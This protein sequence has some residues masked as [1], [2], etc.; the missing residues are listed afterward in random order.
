MTASPG[1][2]GST[3]RVDAAA[4]PTDYLELARELSLIHGRVMVSRESSGIHFYM[5]S[6][7]CLEKDGRI[8]LYKRHLA[9]NADK[10][11]QKGKQRCAMCMKTSHPYTIEELLEMP[12]LAERGIKD[13][14]KGTALVTVAETNPDDL[15]ADS[16]GRLVPKVAGDLVPAYQLPADHPAR[17]YLAYREFDALRL[18]QQFRLSWCE[19]ERVDRF[20]RPLPLGFAATPQGRLVFHV[21]M[22]GKS[23][24]WQARV[25]ELP[26]EDDCTLFWWH[27]Y[28]NE[29]FPV[30]QRNS[31]EEKWE[32][33]PETVSLCKEMPKYLFGKGQARNQVLMGLDAAIAWNRGRQVPVC[34]LAEGAF[35]A[36]RA[37]PPGIATLGKFISPF[38]TEILVRHFKRIV[39]VADNDEAGTYAK[40]KLAD[41]LKEHSQVE[42]HFVAPPAKDLGDTPPAVAA[43]LLKGYL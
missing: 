21:D 23:H 27:P 34:I 40:E 9:V 22:M 1:L 19:L 7:E 30:K 3:S 6:P 38:Q 36:G 35:D 12:P 20:H 16:Q 26:S 14:P 31:P 5:A 11:I 13:A 10:Y 39:Y 33:L 37:G 18:Y 25:L 8:E 43:A 24:G 42:V 28:D 17:Q 15:E 29:W 4:L 41:R 2:I 32:P